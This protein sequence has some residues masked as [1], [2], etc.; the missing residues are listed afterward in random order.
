MIKAALKTSSINTKTN[1]RDGRL[2]AGTFAAFDKYLT[3]FAGEVTQAKA[4]AQTALDT[5]K[6]EDLTKSDAVVKTT[7]EVKTKTETALD[8]NKSL[9]IINSKITYEHPERADKTIKPVDK[10]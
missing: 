9:A 10:N 6:A 2:G 1:E 3:T 4:D 8:E 7:E 5:K